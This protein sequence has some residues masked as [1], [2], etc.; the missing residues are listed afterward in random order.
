LRPALPTGGDALHVFLLVSWQETPL[1]PEVLEVARELDK[2][3]KARDLQRGAREHPEFALLVSQM[4]PAAL[5][6]KARHRMRPASAFQARA[7][8][9][10]VRLKCRGGQDCDFRARNPM[11]AETALCLMRRRLA[12]AHPP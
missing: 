4:R 9:G 1:G 7:G 12:G 10:E 6:A 2:A 5:S 3:T 8:A 11:G